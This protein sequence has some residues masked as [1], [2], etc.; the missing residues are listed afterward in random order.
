MA[1]TIKLKNGSG[2]PTT[3]DLVQ[4]EPALD[5]TNKR[6]YTENASGVVIEVGTNPSTIDINAGTIDGTVIGGSSAAAGTFTTL[7]ASGEITANGGIA[8]GDNDKATFGASDDLEIYHDGSNSIIKDSGAGNIQLQ[9]SGQI[10]IGD[11]AAAETFALFNNDGAVGLYYNNSEKLATTATGIDVTGTVTADSATIQGATVSSVSIQA[12]DTTSSAFVYFGDSDAA[13]RG[14]L[15]F[16]NTDESLNF[17]AGSLATPD[18]TIS[19]AG[20]VDIAGTVT[21]GG[22]ITVNAATASLFLNE[23]D[24]TDENTQLLQASGTFRIRT[25]D[26]SGS[27]VAERLR[28]DHG[29]G[30]LSLYEDTG[31]TAKF[32]WDAS[33]ELLLIGEDS[34]NRIGTGA[35]LALGDIDGG[36]LSIGSTKLNDFNAGDIMGSIEFRNVDGSVAEKTKAKIVAVDDASTGASAYP[37]GVA[38]A[39][40]TI[41]A[42]TLAERVRI[43]GSGSVGIGTSSPAAKLE[44][45]GAGEGIILASPDGTRYEITVANGGTLTVTAV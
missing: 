28:I 18:M 15:E 14:G 11:N 36:L 26:D 1:S 9:T 10:F 34:S 6:L 20:N 25:A 30:D 2:A 35:N 42:G 17:Y 22:T 41:S 29:T 19:T 27:N 24:T 45:G 33:Q 43:T 39:F 3:G 31:T 32:F 16:K 38:L 5:L 40:S 21:T 7:T 44:I 8:L 37:L 4:G 12:G 23:T 13:F